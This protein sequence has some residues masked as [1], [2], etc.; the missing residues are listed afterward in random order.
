MSNLPAWPDP[1]PPPESTTPL[2]DDVSRLSSTPVMSVF[3]PTSEEGLI[4]ILQD[5]MEKNLPICPRGTQH[6]MGGHSTPGEKGVSID[7]KYL[8]TISYCP[9]SQTVTCGPGC[10]WADLIVYLD[11][12]GRGPHTMQSYCT[13][14]V[15]GTLSVNAHG[16][17]TDDTMSS[18]VESMR[19]AVV[20]GDE[21]VVQTVRP[22]DE[23]FKHVLGGYGLFAVIVSATLLTSPNHTLTPSS[24]QLKIPGGEFHRVYQSV[25][26]DPN[27]CVKIARLNILDG[28]QTAQLILFTKASPTPS[29]SINLGLTPRGMNIKT[30]LLY[31]WAMPALRELRYSV[32]KTTGQ[33]IDMTGGQSLTR[34]ELLFE[35]AV[36]LAKVR[37][38]E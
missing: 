20:T 38:V 13:F 32:E 26:S 1:L 7:M 29:S 24:L 2:V 37:S 33:A 23:L 36:P 35:S 18:C 14:S 5:C 25:L 19:I 4:A 21:P 3:Q 9:T 10:L 6:S 8:R 28:L 16:I 30:Q 11:K 34:N 27:V 15:G 12:Y 22:G 31:K 17:T